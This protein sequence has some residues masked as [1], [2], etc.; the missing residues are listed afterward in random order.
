MGVLKY[1]LLYNFRKKK[2][3]LLMSLVLGLVLLG[4]M[5]G[6]CLFFN[7]RTNEQRAFRYSGP[8]LR[9][10]NVNYDKQTLEAIENIPHV[11]NVDYYTWYDLIPTECKSVHE[12]SGYKATEDQMACN[13]MG[14]IT[15]SDVSIDEWFLQEEN[16][17]LFEGAFPTDDNPGIMIEEKFA[18]LNH[19]GLNDE[20]A[21]TLIGREKT[22]PIKLKVCG[23]YKVDTEFVL[24]EDAAG[25]SRIFGFHPAN[26]V[27][28]NTEL[29]TGLLGEDITTNSH[30]NIFIDKFSSYD[31]VEKSL[32]EL[33]GDNFNLVNRAS[34]YLDTSTGIVT[35]MQKLSTS[36]L[37]YVS[38]IGIIIIQI[39]LAFF[40]MQYKREMGLLMALGYK[41]VKIV[42]MYLCSMMVVVITALLLSLVVYTAS[43]NEFMKVV[44]EQVI[45]TYE[46]NVFYGSAGFE[47][48]GLKYCF[49]MQMD[50]MN[51]FSSASNIVYI[52]LAAFVLLIV[53]VSIPIYVLCTTKPRVLLND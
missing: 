44:D 12:Y 1:A 52:I 50:S 49:T 31:S 11:T 9:A 24:N 35:V 13:E 38:I 5:L 21:F 51:L 48:T 22:M 39:L 6:L 29:I 4:F 18:T 41:K 30:R 43:R 8:A 19:L 20:V 16:V 25:D 15:H 26:R 53:M 45:Q 42:R 10:E 47:A 46:S 7:A 28:A 36:I 2:S 33:L 14:L 17:S 3:F 23:I 34:T 27:Y 37:F 32:K 40:A